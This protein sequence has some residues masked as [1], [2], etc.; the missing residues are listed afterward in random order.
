MFKVGDKVKIKSWDKMVKEYGL[1]ADGNILC[2]YKFTVDMK[3]LC[4]E[5]FTIYSIFEKYTVYF[6]NAD[7]DWMYS[8]DMIEKSGIHFK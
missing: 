4:G 3:Y 5:T 8:T 6:E 2:K 7:D 1:N